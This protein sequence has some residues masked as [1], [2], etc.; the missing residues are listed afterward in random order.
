MKRR[1]VLR[2]PKKVFQKGRRSDKIRSAKLHQD[3]NVD[4][5]YTIYNTREVIPS[6]PRPKV[7][8]KVKPEQQLT[9]EEARSH[10]K[11]ISIEELGY[12]CHHPNYKGNRVELDGPVPKFTI[13]RTDGE[14]SF[15]YDVTKK[16]IMVMSSYEDDDPR[17]CFV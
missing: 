4:A 1:G 17:P 15:V 10:L 13:I 7:A 3:E 2:V 6:T 8:L 12:A 16:I 11:W 5:P 14:I 9:L